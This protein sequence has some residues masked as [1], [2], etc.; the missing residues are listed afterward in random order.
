MTAHSIAM[1]AI[2]FC[3]VTEAGRELCFKYAA[4]RQD[5]HFLLLPVTWLGIGFWAVELV[6][7]TAVLAWV[8]LSIAFPLMAL[9]YVALALGAAALFKE[10][11]DRRRAIGIALITGGVLCIGAGGL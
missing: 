1:I 9:S 7:W 10:R 6:T 11:I 3:I 8:P 2:A 4:M 5:R